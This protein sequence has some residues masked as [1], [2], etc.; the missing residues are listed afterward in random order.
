MTEKDFVKGREARIFEVKPFGD[1]GA[2]VTLPKELKGKKV[3]VFV[4]W[5]DGDDSERI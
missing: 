2:H 5:G 1:G 4:P 3:I